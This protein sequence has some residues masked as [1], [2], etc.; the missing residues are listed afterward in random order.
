MVFWIFGWGK[1]YSVVVFEAIAT[2][3]VLADDMDC[4]I[5]YRQKHVNSI[6]ISVTSEKL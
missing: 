5:P 1:N 6:Y 3:I 2:I 4:T